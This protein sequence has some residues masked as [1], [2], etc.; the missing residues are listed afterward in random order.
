MK[1]CSKCKEEKPLHLFNKDKSRYDGLDNK[2]R[3]CRKKVRKKYY[4]NNTEK[5]KS[6]VKEYKVNNP[7]KRKETRAK[8]KFNNKDKMALSSAKYRLKQQGYKGDNLLIALQIYKL[9][10]HI[11]N[12]TKK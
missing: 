6:S 3:D 5:V 4:E 1:Q 10:K 9:N 11:E 12:G 8:Y 2:C 7:E